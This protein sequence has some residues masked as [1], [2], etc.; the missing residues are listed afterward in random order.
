M[1]NLANFSSVL[2][3]K[4][5]FFAKSQ[6]P[7]LFSASHSQGDYVSNAVK[8]LKYITS[9]KKIFIWKKKNFIIMKKFQNEKD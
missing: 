3:T 8:N 9:L 2:Q 4:Y 1:T 5:T 7:Y 6:T